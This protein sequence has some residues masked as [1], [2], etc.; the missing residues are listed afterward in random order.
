MTKLKRKTMAVGASG[1]SIS[2]NIGALERIRYPINV[3][4]RATAIFPRKKMRVP[5]PL[6][7][8]KVAAF[9]RARI[10]KF[11]GL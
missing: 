9:L 6:V 10:K 3:L 7:M 4:H 5:T 2:S 1:Y 8:K 11:W